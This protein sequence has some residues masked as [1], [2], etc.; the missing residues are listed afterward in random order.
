MA[1]KILIVGPSWVGD[2]VMV[3]SLT[4][5]LEKQHPGCEIDILAPGWSL[6]IIQ[7]MPQVRRGLELP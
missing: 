2:M 6:P 1:R 7:R 5:R 3:Q 4:M